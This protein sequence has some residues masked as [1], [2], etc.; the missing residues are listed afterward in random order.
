M[1]RFSSFLRSLWTTS[2]FVSSISLSCHLQTC[3]GW[4]LSH[5]LGN[6]W[7]PK[8]AVPEDH[9]LLRHIT[10]K[11]SPNGFCATV[12][13][14][15]ITSPTKILL[16]YIQCSPFYQIM[17][18]WKGIYLVTDDF[19]FVNPYWLTFLSFKYLEQLSHSSSHPP[20]WRVVLSFSPQEPPTNNHDLTFLR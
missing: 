9:L 5:H 8:T 4:S 12:R 16:N 3:W 14:E 19:H 6:S 13:E 7:T 15:D 2:T 11:W 20:W 17:S 1:L 10:F 18:V